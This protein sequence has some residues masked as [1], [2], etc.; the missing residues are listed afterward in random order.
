MKLNGDE[1]GIKELKTIRETKVNYL[2]YLITEAN[3]NFDHT[4]RFK[5]ADG[6]KRYKL[7][8]SPQ[9]G[10]YTVELDEQL[11]KK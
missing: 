1:E 8:F 2:K 7:I 6:T 3:T 10:E 4:A 5:S 11:E 9:T